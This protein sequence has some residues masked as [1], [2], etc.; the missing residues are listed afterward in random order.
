MRALLLGDCGHGPAVVRHCWLAA[1]VLILVVAAERVILSLHRAVSLVDARALRVSRRL[2][3][4]DKRCLSAGDALLADDLVLGLGLLADNI[5]NRV[6]QCLL[7]FAESVL[8][9]GV[10]HHLAVELVALHARLKQI[11]ARFVVGLLVK[12][13]GA[14]VVHKLLEFVGLPAAEFFQRRFNFLF[15]NVV[16]L[17]VFRA[18]GQ[19]L[20]R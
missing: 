8:L 19:T 15:F 10:V 7:I 14:A 6:F 17:L 5:Q 2:L 16:V 3:L 1:A 9:P 20:P 4:L 11:Q 12:L 18:T 13:Q